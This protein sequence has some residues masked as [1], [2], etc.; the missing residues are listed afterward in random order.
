M[1]VTDVSAACL[2]PTVLHLQKKKRRAV[3]EAAEE[4]VPQDSSAAGAV[5]EA[6]RKKH[7]HG[8]VAPDSSSTQAQKPGKTKKPR[9]SLEPG[10]ALGGQRTTDMMQLL[11]G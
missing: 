8:V 7:K 4:A 10:S 2:R 1:R 9:K 5:G 3:E 11:V 6:K